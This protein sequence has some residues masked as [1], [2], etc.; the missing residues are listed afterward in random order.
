[1]KILAW[2]IE[3][4]PN[5]IWDWKV[6]GDRY[7]PPERMEL[8]GQVLCVGA[9]WLGS[10][11]FHWFSTQDREAMLQGV[12]DLIN[13]ADALL[14]W[15]GKNFD[16]RHMNTEF[17]FAGMTPPS[18]SV[19][20]D[21][22]RAGKRRFAL[23]YNKLDYV[24]RAL[25]L[26]GK[27]QHEGWEMWKGCMDNDPAAWRKMRRYNRRDVFVLEE[28]HGL[29]LPWI[30]SYPNRALYD[31]TEG[32]CPRCGS[33]N[34]QRRGFAVTTVSRFQRW[35][36]QDCGAWSRSAAREAGTDLRGVA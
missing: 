22:M 17:L 12:W 25:G 16:T 30:P 14:S 35:A 15:N 31:H 9:K 28:L 5:L 18:A 24:A 8:R 3:R 32:K 19:E 33:S 4:V 2:D 1:V 20:I 36:C 34:L 11:R 10:K 13:E 23:P 7:I 29:L 27:V 6:W 26:P 21:L